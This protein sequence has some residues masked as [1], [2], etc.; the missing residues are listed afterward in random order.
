MWARLWI[1]CFHNMQ[2]VSCW[3]FLEKKK[4]KTL[5]KVLERIWTGIGVE[6]SDE[7]LGYRELESA[8]TGCSAPIRTRSGENLE[9][10]L[11][12]NVIR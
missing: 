8:L 11:A 12:V 6:W 9:Q 1:E 7:G 3:K 2:T 4:K 5:S 10:V